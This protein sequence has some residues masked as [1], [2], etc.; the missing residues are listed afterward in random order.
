M[1]SQTGT[2]NLGELLSV[3]IDAAE[4]AGGI[5]RSVWKSGKLDIKEKGIDDPFTKADVESQQLIMALLNKQWPELAVVGEEDCQIPPTDDT[6][7][8][9]RVDLSKVPEEYR[10]ISI[11]DLCVF[12]DPLDATKEYTVGNLDA[13]MS[14]VGIGYKGEAVAGVMFQPFVGGQHGN[15]RTIWGLKGMGAFGFEYKNRNDGRFV[16]A[17][18]RTH[19]SE[20]VEKAIATTNP[21]EVIRVGGAGHKALLVMEGVVDIYIFASAGTKKWDTCAPEAIVRSIGG[22][23][24][25]IHG[26]SFSYFKTSSLPNP[27]GIL[28]TLKDHQKY[29]QLMNE[30]LPQTKL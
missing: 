2:L 1:N 11:N 6:P 8:L 15:G 21:S 12:I 29:V 16:V 10:N 17:T 25:D 18:T 20:Q 9:N 3:A 13:V 22:T 4:K 28:C 24:T 30:F 27:D 23:L 14:L 26:K 5:I 7:Q 19:G